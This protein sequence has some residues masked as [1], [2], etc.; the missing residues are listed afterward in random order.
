MT[1]HELETITLEATDLIGGFFNDLQ[2]DPRISLKVLITIVAGQAAL[3]GLTKETLLT[4]VDRAYGQVL[5]AMEL[6]DGAD[7]H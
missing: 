5:A 3:V 2:L 4:C 6:M 7:I 1:N